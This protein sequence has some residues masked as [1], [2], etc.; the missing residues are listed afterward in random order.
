MVLFDEHEEIF[1]SPRVE[2]LLLA[3]IIVQNDALQSGSLGD[4][5]E[6]WQM[7]FDVLIHGSFAWGRYFF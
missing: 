6:A 5:F 1:R 2:D 3:E 4:G 7:L